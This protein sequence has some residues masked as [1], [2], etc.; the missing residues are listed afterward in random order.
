MSQWRALSFSQP[1]LD[2]T[3]RA[4]RGE[5]DPKLVENRRWNTKLRGPFILHAAKSYDGD[6][7]E[8]ALRRGLSKSHLPE[9]QRG[10]IVGIARLVGTISM[11]KGADRIRVDAA[12]YPCSIAV[13][14]GTESLVIESRRYDLRWWMRDQYGFL[15]TDVCALPFTPHRGA[16]GFWR[17]PAPVV[18]SL[19]LP[20]TPEGWSP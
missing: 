15:L 9:L 1:W 8:W 12:I 4:A 10:G 6:A 14:S 5:P 13:D 17:V 19:G 20:H 3:M 7:W 2:F 16:L 11:M 18:A